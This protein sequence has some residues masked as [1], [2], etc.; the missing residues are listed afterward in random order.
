MTQP[1][2]LTIRRRRKAMKLTQVGLAT[3]AGVDRGHVNRI[4]RGRVAPGFDTIK[5]I[6]K[7]LK[8]SPSRLLM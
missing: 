8:T 1:I 5:R 4:E 6:A 3:K 2:G 7:A